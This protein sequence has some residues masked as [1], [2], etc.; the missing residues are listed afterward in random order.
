MVKKKRKEDREKFKVRYIGETNRSGYERGK[1]HMDHFRNMQEKSH[2]L[3][4]YLTCHKGI[5][6]DEMEVGMRIK[7][8]F[9][10]AIERQISEA[11]AIS[12]AETDGI[13]LMNSKAEYNRCKLPRLNTQSIEDQMEE[14]ESVKKKEK[15]MEKEIREL[16]K[17]KKTRK[18]EEIIEEEMEKETLESVCESILKEGEPVWKKRKIE[19]EKKKREEEKILNLENEKRIRLFEAER[20]KEETKKKLIKKGLIE[21]E[22]KKE[23][24]KTL[25]RKLW[26]ISTVQTQGSLTPKI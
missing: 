16:K 17:Q 12:R 9:K 4:H 15:E 6:I 24:W 7:S 8:S 26:R 23:S 13:M 19:E 3:K 10:S 20:K 21:K 5:S 22:S 14:L 2:L 25:K 1:E 11:V 18:K